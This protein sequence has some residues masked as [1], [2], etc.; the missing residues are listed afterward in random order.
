MLPGLRS[1]WT[2]PTGVRVHGIGER[3]T[4]GDRRRLRNSPILLGE[5]PL[6][7]LHREVRPAVY[8]AG[9]VHRHE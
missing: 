6:D 8:F 5:S 9:V 4:R 3:A 7:E 1:R 2:I